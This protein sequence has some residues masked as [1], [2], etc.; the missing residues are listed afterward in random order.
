MGALVFLMNE[1][2]N[3]FHFILLFYFLPDLTLG[4]K[5]VPFFLHTRGY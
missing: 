2:L 4:P 3:F 5:F 1:L